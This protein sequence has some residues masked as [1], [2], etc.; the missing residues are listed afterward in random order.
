MSIAH[1]IRFEGLGSERRRQ[2]KYYAAKEEEYTR[3]FSKGF[4]LIDIVK[5]GSETTNDG[6]TARR[7]FEFPE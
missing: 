2:Q 7:F 6:N 4:L 3:W 1:C 5:Q